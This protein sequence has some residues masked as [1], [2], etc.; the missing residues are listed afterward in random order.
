MAYSLEVP[1]LCQNDNSDGGDRAQGQNNRDIPLL[2]PEAHFGD[3]MFLLVVVSTAVFVVHELDGSLSLMAV[4][5][6]S[7]L[8]PHENQPQVEGG[9]EEKGKRKEEG[10]GPGRMRV[11][12][13]ENLKIN[14]REK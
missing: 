9:L 4:N 14:L 8:T 5:I 6:E 7:T 13:S 12:G 11:K 10:G 1:V 3:L 2:L